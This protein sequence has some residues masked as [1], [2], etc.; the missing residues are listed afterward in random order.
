MRFSP[1]LAEIRFGYGLSPDIA[2]PVSLT[3]MLDGLR[4]QDHMAARFPIDTYETFRAEITKGHELRR[5]ARN[6]REDLGLRR[7]IAKANRSVVEKSNRWMMRAML[8]ATWSRTAFRERLVAFWADHFTAQGKRNPLTN[9]VSPYVEGAIRPHI[10]GR[11]GDLLIAAVTHPMMLHYL[12]QT[13]SA[14]PGSRAVKRNK[15]LKGLNENLAREVLELHTLGVGAPYSQGDVRQ[16]AELFTG[17]NMNRDGVL[18]YRANWAEP[19]P[20]TILGRSYGGN[21]GQLE[22]I[23][24]ALHDIAVHPATAEHIARKLVQHFVSDTPDE[25]LVAHI[26]ARF[27]ATNGDLMQVYG[28]L[29]EHPA[30]WVDELSN[31][32]PHIDYVTSACR[33]LAVS[34]KTIRSA[35]IRDIRRAVVGPLRVMGQRWQRPSGPDGWPEEDEAWATPQGVAARLQWAISVPQL[36]K[37]QLPDPVGFVDT[38]L[39]A[40]AT[41][42]VRFAAEAAES[43][44]EAI[45]LVLSAPAFQRR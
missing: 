4:A 1:Q 20:E 44:A 17:L 19:G 11:F 23:H 25:A 40:Y 7:A 5:A 29:L 14:G 24:Q 21:P 8:R 28:A 30:A 13:T 15:R 3:A 27:S 2:A 41:P 34:P 38:T 6:A 10:T 36:L 26:A 32:K 45:G 37:P 18:R 39:G 12:D 33:A 22:H 16:L 31:V 43:R 42:A 35:R 9:G